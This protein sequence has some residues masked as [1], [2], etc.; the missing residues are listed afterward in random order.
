MPALWACQ[1]ETP[2]SACID[3]SVTY[4]KI[5]CTA[6][7]DPV[8]GC[9]GNTYTNA[10]VAKFRHGVLIYTKGACG[11]QYPYRG[12]VRDYTGLDGLMVVALSLTCPMDYI[13]SPFGC[14]QDL[15]YRW[16]AR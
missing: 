4:N 10:C 3:L 12:V 7:Y 15:F 14:R 5:A 16:A 11:C 6:D 13:W 2:H 9:D 1:K 8:C